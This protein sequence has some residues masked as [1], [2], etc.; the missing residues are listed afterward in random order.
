MEKAR[1]EATRPE[2]KASPLTSVDVLQNLHQLWSSILQRL[3]E[4][5]AKSIQQVVP[6]SWANDTLTVGSSGP[7]ADQVLAAIHQ[8]LL[9]STGAQSASI[10]VQQL[11]PEKRALR[12]TDEAW[13]AVQ[14]SEFVQNI[15]RLFNGRVVD[16][17]G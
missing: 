4:G 12:P 13:A 10:S 15:C 5:L 14:N 8:G 11:E 2:K 17:R 9:A 16:V 7:V 3:P 6:I 1:P